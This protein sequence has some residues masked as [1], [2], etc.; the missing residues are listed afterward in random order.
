MGGIYPT[1]NTTGKAGDGG[2]GRRN[3]T[4]LKA[5]FS[6][7]P[8]YNDYKNTEAVKTAVD[9]DGK[10]AGPVLTGEAESVNDGGVWGFS[11]FNLDFVD[12]PNVSEVETG[13]EGKPASPYYPNITS[14]GEGNANNPQAQPE[15]TGDPIR[16]NSV[17]GTGLG[18]TANPAN[19]SKSIAEKTVG[20]YISGR[21]FQGSDGRS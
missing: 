9:V 17:Y 5:S 6:G 2:L 1:V 8:V 7:S 14:P 21:S 12:A 11:S 3:Q 15:Y 18:A 19:T 13:G 16:K 4:N 10:P 20:S